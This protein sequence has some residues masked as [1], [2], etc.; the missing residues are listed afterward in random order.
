MA[1][2]ALVTSAAAA[3]AGACG[4]GVVPAIVA[5]GAMGAAV[6]VQAGEGP[7]A[8]IITL[9]LKV[10][11]D[12]SATAAGLSPCPDG[13]APCCASVISCPG[14]PSADVCS[15]CSWSLTCPSADMSRVGP[16]DEEEEPL[17]G[18]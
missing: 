10:S 3:A 17:R 7:S 6:P 16:S 11:R 12:A 14:E 8:D 1:V 18:C 2:A 13:P 15:S 4:G 5:D 9:S